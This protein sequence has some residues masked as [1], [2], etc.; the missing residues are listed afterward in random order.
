M[1][2]ASNLFIVNSPIFDLGDFNIH[3][4]C[5]VTFPVPLSGPPQLV[6]PLYDK[7]MVGCPVVGVITVAVPESKPVQLDMVGTSVNVKVLLLSV[8]VMFPVTAVAAEYEPVMFVPVCVNTNV[9][10]LVPITEELRLPF[11]VPLTSRAG[12]GGVLTGKVA[13]VV[14][15]ALSDPPPPQPAKRTHIP[16]RTIKRFMTTSV[17]FDFM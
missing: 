8:P 3:N 7:L 5:L 10:V 15:A 13:C 11:Q 2:T 12:V 1:E 4:Y 6:E 14:G 17:N 16:P 9:V